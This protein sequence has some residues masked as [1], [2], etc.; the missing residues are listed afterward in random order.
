MYSTSWLEVFTLFSTRLFA[1]FRGSSS[2]IT[3]LSHPPESHR[4]W[5]DYA[6]MIVAVFRDSTATLLCQISAHGAPRLLMRRGSH[7]V[8][9]QDKFVLNLDDEHKNLQSDQP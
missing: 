4:R 3:T 5:P 1:A 6:G 7:Y 9:P 2:R 8:Q